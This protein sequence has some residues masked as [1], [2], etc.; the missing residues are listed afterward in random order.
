MVGPE[1]YQAP[2]VALQQGIGT[3]PAYFFSGQTGQTSHG[4]QPQPQRQPT[5]PQQQT[6]SGFPGSG[7]PMTSHYGSQSALPMY[8]TTRMFPQQ[9]RL[10]LVDRV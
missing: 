7:I 8:Q 1:G 4:Y 5:P 3:M 9:V 6:Q 2:T 10:E